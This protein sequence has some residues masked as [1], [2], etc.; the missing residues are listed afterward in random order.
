VILYFHGG[1][2]FFLGL[3]AYR[4]LATRLSAA[5][6]RP[7]L[8][9]DYRMLPAVDFATVI[10]DCVAAYEWLL[11][12][13]ARPAD[14]A[15]A[16]DSAGGHL[17]FA[18]QVHARERGLPM[19]GCIVAL[20]PCLDLDFTAKFAHPNAARAKASARTLHELHRVFLASLDA[21]D[22]LVSPIHADL[23]GFPASLLVVSSTETLFCDS[24]LMAHRLAE[25]GVA[26]KLLIWDRQQH[27]FPALGNL[28]PEA[29]AAIAEIAEFIKA[30]H[31]HESHREGD[32]G[33]IRPEQDRRSSETAGGG[34]R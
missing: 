1:G 25:A 8:S 4:R 27:V 34:P 16:G 31:Y 14:V 24:E 10:N 9:V 5:T 26:H 21:S 30:A 17:A 13:G 28:T 3:N 7:V 23:H 33:G 22:P 15:V 6:G 12:S 29:K 32:A 20:S 2:W 19:A 18:M 11:D